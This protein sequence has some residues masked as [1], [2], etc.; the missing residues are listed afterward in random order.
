MT[1]LERSRF[2]AESANEEAPQRLGPLGSARRWMDQTTETI[3]SH[4]GWTSGLGDCCSDCKSCCVVM[5]CQSTVVGQLLERLTRRKWTCV[6]VSSLLWLGALANLCAD[7]YTPSCSGYMDDNHDGTVSDHE[8]ARNI[9]ANQDGEASVSEMEG[10][11]Q[12]YLDCQ[13]A[14][15]ASTPFLLTTFLGS[16]FMLGV[17]VLTWCIRAQIRKRDNIPP[18]V[19]S[20]LDDCICALCC[21]MC[22][23]C[24]IM[25]HEGLV[26]SKYRL[27][28]PDGSTTFGGF[29]EMEEEV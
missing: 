16:S 7:W 17:C 11:M 8:L 18:T 24:Q 25:R 21:L 6:V 13:G 9:D 5:I 23:Q 27:F 29:S 15:Y 1:P 22:T 10:A 4:H 12:P 14:Y 20:G 28:S 2:A 3:R 26:G 19:C